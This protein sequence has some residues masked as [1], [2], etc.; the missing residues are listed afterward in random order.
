[1]SESRE[2]QS[3][4]SSLGEQYMGWCAMVMTQGVSLRLTA[5][6]SASTNAYMSGSSSSENSPTLKKASDW[7]M[8]TCSRPMLNE[9][10]TDCALRTAAPPGMM[11]KRARYCKKSA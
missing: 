1:M 4:L 7:N 11:S 3:S 6:R 8:M 5:A 9:W 2:W 10:N